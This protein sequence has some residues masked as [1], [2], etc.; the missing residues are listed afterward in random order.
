MIDLTLQMAETAVKTAQ[1]KAR[2]LG[3]PMTVTAAA[4]FRR[5]TAELTSPARRR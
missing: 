3:A 2:A 1:A 4:A 5:S